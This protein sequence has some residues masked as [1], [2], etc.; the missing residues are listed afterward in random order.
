MEV[1][2]RLRHHSAVRNN[3][4]MEWYAILSALGGLSGIG[5][6]ISV[7]FYLRPTRQKITA[8]AKHLEASAKHQTAEADEHTLDG[9]FKLLERVQGR[10]DQAEKKLIDLERVN[11]RYKIMI[12]R[13]LKRIA[14]L[15][16]GIKVLLEQLQA[17]QL[18]PAWK[19]DDEWR[20][21]DEEG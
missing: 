15:M 17:N 10:L 14:Y 18:E 5:A 2:C 12:D 13:A 7:L 19:P 1:C 21:E 3:R 6:L 8:E 11:A 20:L 16:H 4:R 9:A